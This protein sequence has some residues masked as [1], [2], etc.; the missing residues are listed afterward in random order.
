M[1]WTR[2]PWF[3]KYQ[4][5]TFTPLW[6]AYIII[7]NALTFRQSGRCMLRNDTGYFLLLF[8]LSAVFWWFFEFLNR[9]VQNWYYVG[10]Q[11]SALE[12]FFFATLPF[13]TVLPAVLGTRDWLLGFSWPEK[14][15]GNAISIRVSHP[16]PLALCVLIFAGIGLAGIGVW[17]NYLFPLLW[18]SPF[19]IMI[20]LQTL[21]GD[22]HIFSDITFGYWAIILTSAIAALLCGFFWEMWNLFSLAK[23]KYSIPFVH[24]FQLFEM[25][26]LGYGG[27][28]PFGLECAFIGDMLFLKKDR[29]S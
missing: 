14:R 24:R 6:V 29:A 22:Y 18:V 1:A 11:F 13:S 10:S 15:F 20:S 2:I 28:L 27:Y 9:F 25:P 3:S 16:K 4:A 26:I 7:I 23:W 21:F 12:Y 19:L 17:P 5:H 8:P